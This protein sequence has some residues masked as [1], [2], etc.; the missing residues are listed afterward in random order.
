MKHAL[1]LIA[2]LA[3]LGG[4]ATDGAVIVPPKIEVPVAVPCKTPDPAEPQYQYK[5]PYTSTFDGTRDLLGD[6]QQSLAYEIQLKAALK[7][8]R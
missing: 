3:A 5:P 7:S 1:L 4:C 6:H 8:C 2:V